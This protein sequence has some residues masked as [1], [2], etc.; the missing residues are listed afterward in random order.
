MPHFSQC[1]SV[2]RPSGLANYTL[3]LSSLGDHNEFT[4]GMKRFAAIIFIADGAH[5]VEVDSAMLQSAYGLTVAETKVAVTLLKLGSAKEVA[6]T[7]G[8][9][10]GT[11][12]S[13]IKQI[14]LKLGVDSRAR[15]VKLM[16]GLASYS[17]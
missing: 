15:F 11:V 3:Q 17:P 9:S 14:Y 12:R 16:L 7:L 8:V 2:P 5:E 4:A 6:D 13:Q 10:S 1:I